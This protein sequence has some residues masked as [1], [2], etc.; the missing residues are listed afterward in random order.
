MTA[1]D[2]IIKSRKSTYPKDYNQE[3]ITRE[4]LERLLSVTSFAP[5]HKKT[6]PWR[7]HVF[8]GEA[9]NALGEKLASVYKET[10]DPEKFLENKM[11][12]IQEKAVQSQ[13]VICIVH[14]ISQSVPEWEEH[15]AIAMSVQNLWLKATELG[16]GGYWSTPSLVRHLDDYL[17]LEENENCLG[18]FYLGKTDYE[19]PV[20]EHDW[21]EYVVFR[22]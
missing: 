6:R 8:T 14:H 13:V 16:I 1:L 3:E 15:A 5:N 10:T 18:F 11:K 20:K 9:K 7:F 19:F 17:S 21:K 12:S 22:D 2:T 4:E